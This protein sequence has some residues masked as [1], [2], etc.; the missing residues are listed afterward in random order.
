MSARYWSAVQQLSAK[1][2]Q[3]VAP[4]MLVRRRRRRVKA[5]A[6][7]ASMPV[8]SIAAP[9]TI[10]HSTRQIVGTMPI[11]PEVAARSSRRALPVDRV[12]SLRSTVTG[13]SPA[14]NCGWAIQMQAV[15]RAALTHSTSRVFMRQAMSMPVISGTTST[16]GVMLKV[17]C[18]APSSS[19][20]PAWSAS[21]PEVKPTMVNTVR[22]ASSA[23]VVVTNI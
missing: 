4:T 13:L 7:E 1:P 16:H 5:P 2:E 17:E 19:G 12:V 8:P 6:I 3:A 9:K 23:G 21:P 10:A 15:P 20:S 14:A 18:R 22:A 11:R